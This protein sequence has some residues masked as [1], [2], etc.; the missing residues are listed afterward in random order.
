MSDPSDLV[1]YTGYF[2][3]SGLAIILLT[4][5]WKLI[6]A[7]RAEIQMMRELQDDNARLRALIEVRDVEN[8][9]LL[10]DS[11]MHQADLKSAISKIDFLSE[12]IEFL[13]NEIS[14]MKSATRG[15]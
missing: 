8:R 4:R 11:L 3:T 1:T 7:D 9:A 5:V 14:S 6:F 12:Q 10:R 15:T 13:K 2:G